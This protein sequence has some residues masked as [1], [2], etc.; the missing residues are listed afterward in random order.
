MDNF[1]CEWGKLKKA[2]IVNN[3]CIFAK[4]IYMKI[5]SYLSEMRFPGVYVIENHTNKTKRYVGSSF[6]PYGRLHKHLH[7]LK[8][9]KHENRYLQNAW[10]K[11]GKDKFECYIVEF[12]NDNTLV[13]EDLNKILLKKEQYWIDLLNPE[14]NITKNVERNLLSKESKLLISKTL[15]E[16]YSSGRIKSTSC[17]KI[18]AFDLDGNFIKEFE[19]CRKACEELNLSLSSVTRV[20]KN[21]YSQAKNY[22]FRYSE[23]DDR[24]VEK[25]NKS[26]YLRRK[27]DSKKPFKK[28]YVYK[29]NVFIGEFGSIK[30][31]AEKLKLHPENVSQVFR[32]AKESIKGYKILP[33][34]LKKSCELLE[35]LEEDNQQPSVSE[36]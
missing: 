9:N 21:V 12:V 34:P 26:K 17:V 25:I 3:F 36:M 7:N 13:K 1:C 27:K 22:Q 2:A 30:E 32:G 35:N 24:P 10:N 11:Y 28:T 18:K 5:P 16:G 23:N 33:A 4:I 19:S 29:N 31:T 20:L 15:K 14:Y 8:N 6:E